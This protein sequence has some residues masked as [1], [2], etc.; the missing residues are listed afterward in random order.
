MQLLLYNFYNY[1]PEPW[2]VLLL[3]DLKDTLLDR[4]GLPLHVTSDDGQVVIFEMVGVLHRAEVKIPVGVLEAVS[5]KVAIDII[6][7]KIYGKFHGGI[8]RE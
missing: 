3:D 7:D 8:T 2:L 1:G 6:C 4:Y 5:A